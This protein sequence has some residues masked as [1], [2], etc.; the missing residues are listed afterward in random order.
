MA[1]NK[2]SLYSQRSANEQYVNWGKVASDITKG[3]ITVDGERRARKAAIEKQTNET[4]EKL[5]E[6]ADV[7]NGTAS[8]LLIRGSNQSKEN[9]MIQTD[10]LKRGLI[11]PQDYQLFMNQQK[12][13]YKNL[14]TA[15]QNWDKYF[16]EAQTRL[17]PGEDGINS[18]AS[19]AEIYNNESMLAFGNL[20]DKILWTNPTNGQIQLVQMGKDTNGNYTVMPDPKNNPGAFMNPNYM[21]V[22]MNFK[23]NRKILSQQADAV[24]ENI[25]PFI[26]ESMYDGVITSEDDFRNNADFGTK[27]DGTNQ[28][29]DGWLNEQVDGIVAIDSDAVQILTSRG[30][31]LAQDKEEY[32]KKYCE[33][34]KSCDFSKMIKVSYVDGKPEYDIGKDKMDEARRLA[35]NAI[36]VRIGNTIK[37]S[38]RPTPDPDN[39]GRA[40]EIR[41]TKTNII[42]EYNTIL[43]GGNETQVRD[44]LD[45]QIR[46]RNKG[47]TDP[48]KKIV[49]YELTDDTITFT[50]ADGKKSDSLQRRSKIEGDNPATPD[51]VETEYFEGT[52]LTNQIFQLYNE[53]GGDKANS[54]NSAAQVQSAVDEYDIQLGTI[55]EGD[56]LA[57]QYY[58]DPYDMSDAKSQ[59][60]SANDFV[61]AMGGDESGVG[62]MDNT[63][64]QNI[65]PKLDVVVEE[66]FPTELLDEMDKE[67]LTISSNFEAD[68]EEND[69]SFIEYLITD[70]NT[71]T[72]VRTYKVENIYGSASKNPT[73]TYK[74][75]FDEVYKGFILPYLNERNTVRSEANVNQRTGEIGSLD[76]L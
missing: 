45:G 55:R 23:E 39:T 27:E 19:N 38:G 61:I 67:G 41:D 69:P 4:I 43:T 44:L 25:A 66:A 1:E 16:T 24:V 32:K 40:R 52:G 30:Y 36:E 72:V 28:N 2:Y 42:K 35:K 29:Y 63:D 74:D 50:Y 70:K 15:V 26:E 46:I 71:G 49:G 10:L 5:S 76:N 12:T 13:G 60:Q 68:D 17:E 51:V 48:N 11:T 56:K 14:S 53:L 33:D 8:A 22:R 75:I 54:F 7:N 64:I 21:N 31:N 6:V 57:G 47:N 3:I 65:V 20:N 73:K 34:K 59:T 9:L 18:V 58:K 62:R 37:K